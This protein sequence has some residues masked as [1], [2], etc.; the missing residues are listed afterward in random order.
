MSA[1]WHE[2]VAFMREHGVDEA[3]WN[4][5]GDRLVYAKLGEL[6]AEPEPEAE[7]TRA[8]KSKKAEP[9]DPIVE[10][11]RMILGAVSSLREIG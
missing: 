6:P 1:D 2:K 3:R 9:V 8:R 10:R 4:E 5:L 11:R 7:P